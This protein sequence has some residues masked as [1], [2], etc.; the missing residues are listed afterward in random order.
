MDSFN[1]NQSL[2]IPKSRR[3]ATTSQSA[4]SYQ[5]N[6]TNYVFRGWF[7][8]GWKNQATIVVSIEKKNLFFVPSRNKFFFRVESAIKRIKFQW[9]TQ[10]ATPDRVRTFVGRKICRKFE[11]S[12]KGAVV[13]GSRVRTLPGSCFFL[14]FYLSVLHP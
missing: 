8:Y 11:L 5:D 14:S 9:V 2:H 12:N 10:I 3:Y 1:L 7:P 4:L 6:L 13:A